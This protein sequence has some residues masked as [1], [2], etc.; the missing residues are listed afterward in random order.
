MLPVTVVIPA[1]NAVQTLE[2]TL[3]SVLAQSYPNWK[4][5]IVND[6][7]KDNTLQL[8][9]EYAKKDERI[10]VIHQENQGSAGAYN[11]GV[12]AAETE[13]ICICSADDLLM[14][15]HL[16][17]VMT[18]IEKNPKYDIFTTSGARYLLPSGDIKMEPTDPLDASF[19]EECVFD[20]A[21]RGL[22]GVGATYRKAMFEMLG[23][24]TQ[25]I[26]SE[27]HD[28][29]LRAFAADYKFMHIYLSTTIYRISDSQKSADNDKV[30]K[31]QEEIVRRVLSCD[32]K[33][34]E[35]RQGLIEG[36]ALRKAETDAYYEYRDMKGCEL[37]IRRLKSSI[38]N[39]PRIFSAL[40][41]AV[42]HCSKRIRH[43]WDK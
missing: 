37:A 7:S 39:G 10:R 11:T 16:G 32:I 19:H 34:E 38:N 21:R 2:D 40:S 9:Q 43:S 24:Y 1:Y 14:P 12:T 35:I 23:G 17:I 41:R 33:N 30:I 8:A 18:A 31:S 27:D 13:W 4:L 25:H 26:Y 42:Y 3:D 15:N 6:G 5:I 29:W 28:F 20:V 36:A 22:Y